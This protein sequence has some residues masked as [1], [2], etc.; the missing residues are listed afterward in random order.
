ML[1]IILLFDSSVILFSIIVEILI[2]LMHHL[3]AI[4]SRTYK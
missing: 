1:G 3:I 2:G 4:A